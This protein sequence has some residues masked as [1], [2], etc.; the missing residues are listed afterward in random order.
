MKRRSLSPNVLVLGFGIII[1]NP[2]FIQPHAEVNHNSTLTT[3]AFGSFMSFP[4]QLSQFAVLSLITYFLCGRRPFVF[5][6]ARVGF[7]LRMQ[8]AATG[9]GRARPPS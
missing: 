2:G 5:A 4:P 9:E 1:K 8:G 6:L 7:W 3:G